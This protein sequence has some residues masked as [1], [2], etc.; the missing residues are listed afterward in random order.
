MRCVQ[1]CADLIGA[2]VGVLAPIADGSIGVETS[3]VCNTSQMRQYIA[4]KGES[5]GLK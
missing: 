5:V 3:R 1:G 2:A 4:G